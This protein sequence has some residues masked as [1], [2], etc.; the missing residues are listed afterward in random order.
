MYRKRERKRN[1]KLNLQFTGGEKFVRIP[2][3]NTEKKE[4]EKDKKKRAEKL[5][6]ENGSNVAVAVGNA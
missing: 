5:S 6:I 4:K 2:F 1:N 3:V